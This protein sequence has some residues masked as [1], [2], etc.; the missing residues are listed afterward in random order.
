MFK[1]SKRPS[2]KPRNL[3]I[4]LQDID[5]TVSHVRLVADRQK[6]VGSWPT[7]R[8]FLSIFQGLKMRNDAFLFVQWFSDHMPMMC[9][10]CEW[11]LNLILLNHHHWSHHLALSGNRV[12]MNSLVN[13]NLPYINCYLSI[14]HNFQT[15]LILIH[16]FKCCNHKRMQKVG[17]KRTN[18][19]PFCID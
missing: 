16:P 2:P 1:A 14:I 8:L 15:L 3:R 9:D 6:T 10:V 19:R 13:H 17:K 11:N 18:H 5:A 4:L 7:P 12:S